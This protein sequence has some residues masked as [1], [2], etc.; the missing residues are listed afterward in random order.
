MKDI[1]T[2]REKIDRLDRQI[3]ELLNKR[4]EIAS[5]IWRVKEKAGNN[6]F[7]PIREKS[8]LA[9]LK[10]V[11]KNI[12]EK[13]LENIFREIISAIRNTEKKLSVAYL[14]PEG[15]FAQEA[16]IKVFGRSCG[17][18]PAPGFE[19]VFREVEKGLADFGVL[20]IENSVEGSVSPSLNFIKDSPLNIYG[21]KTLQ[22]HH[23][24]VSK[25]TKVSAIKKLYSHPQPL[26]QC[27]KFLERNL[28]S[29]PVIETFS[30]AAAAEKAAKTKNSAALSSLTAAKN[31][32]LNVLKRRVEDY[33]NNFTRFIILSY[34]KAKRSG[35]DKTS[36]VATLKNRPGELYKLLGIFKAKNLNLTK[37]VSRPMP[38]ATWAYLFYIDF[39]GHRDDKKV[40]TAL[41]MIA[42]QTEMMKVL[43]SYPKES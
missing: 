2:Y 10:K 34:Q 28:P 42:R 36:I 30:T 32:G 4:V 8:I 23:N 9:K 27:R 43:G 22:I 12:P 6:V 20:P 41:K 25:L 5:D 29:I 35:K 1:S 38:H 19:A 11:N 40:D 3:V 31:Y 24:L 18:I 26:G 39:E 33:P 37:I 17:Y 16:A 7:D 15:T 14:G 13:S 21:E